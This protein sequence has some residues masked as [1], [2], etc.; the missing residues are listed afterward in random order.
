M[1]TLEHNEIIIIEMWALVLY[2]L[3]TFTSTPHTL[4][5]IALQRYVL[6]EVEC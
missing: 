4:G 1:E 5:R 2:S 6:T 3:L